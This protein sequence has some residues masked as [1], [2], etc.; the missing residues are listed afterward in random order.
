MLCHLPELCVVQDPDTHAHPSERESAP[1]LGFPPR[2]PAD[3]ATVSNHP[4]E[5]TQQHHSSYP[6]AS[7]QLPSSLPAA[8]FCVQNV[9]SAL[10]SPQSSPRMGF[11]SPL[12][13]HNNRTQSRLKPALNKGTHATQ[14][15]TP[16]A[17]GNENAEGE[18]MAQCKGTEHVQG[19]LQRRIAF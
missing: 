18:G 13:P 10:T 16:H 9:T 14:G 11:Q 6:S 4:A 15:S 1:S 8:S 3:S 7:M 2:A 12:S 19:G 5:P 17:Q